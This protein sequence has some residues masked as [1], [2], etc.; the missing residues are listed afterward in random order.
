M[1]ILRSPREIALM[2][3][4]GLLVWKAHRL[5]E[6]MVRPG[7]TTGEI[8]A[9]VEEFFLKNNAE[10]LFKGLTFTLHEGDHVGL[11][12]PNGAGKSTLLKILAGITA[13]SAGEVAVRGEVYDVDAATLAALD[14]LEGYP[15][16]Y[17]REPVEL[18]GEVAG[19][20]LAYLLPRER[21]SERPEIPHGDW[22]AWQ[23]ETRQ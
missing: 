5:A 17:D 23:K 21:V 1:E 6:M 10:P 12:G 3:K 20:A 13:A 19:E 16:F 4:A 22:K 18:H 2:R 7:A 11:I 8:D 9:V 15:G 14:R